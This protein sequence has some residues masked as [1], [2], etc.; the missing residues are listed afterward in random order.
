MR[1]IPL[2]ICSCFAILL[3]SSAFAE[4]PYFDIAPSARRC[5]VRDRNTSQVA[6]DYEEA[7]NAGQN[8]ER[9]ADGRYIYGLQWAEERD[10]T[11]VRVQTQPGSTTAAFRQVFQQLA[12][13]AEHDA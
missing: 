6:F 2:I 9:A 12:A 11:E 3:T 7:R 4:A 10:I 5:C 13:G 1:N 8:A